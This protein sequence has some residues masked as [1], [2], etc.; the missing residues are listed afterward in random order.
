MKKYKSES[1]MDTR[2]TRDRASVANKLE[3]EKLALKK[4]IEKLMREYAKA[5]GHKEL[6]AR[7]HEVGKAPNDWRKIN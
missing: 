1:L 7:Q 3:M 5:S 4:E 6:G 2:E